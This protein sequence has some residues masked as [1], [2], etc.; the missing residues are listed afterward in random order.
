M[1]FHNGAS[2]GGLPEPT[3]YQGLEHH[4]PSDQK[5]VHQLPDGEKE[6]KT[7]PTEPWSGNWHDYQPTILAD[8]ADLQTTH[9][10]PNNL[11][12]R[13]ER[14]WWKRKR[15]WIPLASLLLIGAIVGGIV[16]G[17][18]A[19]KDSSSDK[20]G[21]T[22]SPASTAAAS[23]SSPS[24]TSI[25]AQPTP[26]PLNSSLASVAWS[27]HGTL[28][29][30]RLYYQDA[31]G[32]IKEVGWNSSGNEWYSSNEKLG[33]AKLG[34]PIAAA[35]AGNVT[36]PFQIN[37]YY[38]DPEGQL[39]ERYTN[40]GLSWQNGLL[41]NE[42]IIPSPNSAIAA[43]W[44]QTDHK[45]C[46]NCGQQTILTT[47][48]DSNAKIRVINGTGASPPQTVL[49]ADAVAGTGLAF[50]SV[51][52]SSGSPGIRIYYQKGAGAL[53]TVDYEDSEY[54]ASITGDTAWQWTL[55]ED[56]P[57]GSVSTGSSLA[58]FTWGDDSDSGN[59]LLQF[60][61]SSGP[62]GIGITRLGSSFSATAGGWHDETPD[63][64]KNVQAYS[65]VGANAD[66]LVYALQDGGV[67]EFACSSDGTTW[68]LLGDVPTK[69]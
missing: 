20:G 16:G 34:S 2:D 43:I 62:Q 54:G 69:N 68:S 63:A 36:W 27:D 39:V 45:Y 28:G 26:K 21:S 24:S 3:P 25:P 53:M 55:H 66:R 22:S 49:E 56:T 61:M 64:M 38:L 40:D 4:T 50:Q 30:R 60:T 13:R 48:Q 8:I 1:A 18:S 67:K 44:S 9:S 65:P 12:T 47:Y 19:R 33:S 35:V 41:T 10:G 51:W 37:L 23:P 14:G 6:C 59:P 42:F 29:Y 5:Q 58:S 17:L 32:T 52:H 57:I 11:Q 15:F 46:D 31:A 7:S